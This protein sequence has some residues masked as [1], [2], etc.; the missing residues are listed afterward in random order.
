MILENRRHSRKIVVIH[1]TIDMH[2]CLDLVSG[3]PG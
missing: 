2:P 1:T 3:M